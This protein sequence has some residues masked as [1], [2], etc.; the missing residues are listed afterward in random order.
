MVWWEIPFT[1]A[2]GWLRFKVHSYSQALCIIPGPQGRMLCGGFYVAKTRHKASDLGGLGAWDFS[3]NP[4]SL[5]FRSV[6]L[7]IFCF[8]RLILGGLIWFWCVSCVTGFACWWPMLWFWWIY[9]DIWYLYILYQIYIYNN[10]N[11]SCTPNRPV[12]CAEDL[13]PTKTQ[14]VLQPKA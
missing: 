11:V 3:L 8:T 14:K 4:L 9:K 1:K 2:Q 12:F 13:L 5:R 10:A 7:F 6:L